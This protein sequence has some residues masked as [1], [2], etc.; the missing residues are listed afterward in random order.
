MAYILIFSI[1]LPS[2]NN[3]TIFIFS[4][5]FIKHTLASF[6]KFL[7]ICATESL[8]GIYKPHE[9]SQIIQ[10][11]TC[12]CPDNTSSRLVS[13]LLSPAACFWMPM[14]RWEEAV[15]VVCLASDHRLPDRK[16]ALPCSVCATKRHSS[17]SQVSL[18]L[19]CLCHQEAQSLIASQ[20]CPAMSVPP[21]GTVPDRKSAL[22][23]SVLSVPSRGTTPSSQVSIAISWI[24]SSSPWTRAVTVHHKLE[25][26][27]RVTVSH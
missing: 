3:N 11:S 26:S 13:T 24:P 22:L 12:S 5:Y 15:P 10:S 9:L 27:P 7:C 1:F 2:L 14:P 16:P 4:S 21:R 25:L 8:L 19:P 17:W 6:F 18:A 20:P 23:C